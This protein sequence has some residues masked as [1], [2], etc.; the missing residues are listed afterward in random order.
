M[1]NQ[2]LTSVASSLYISWAWQQAAAA[3]G[4]SKLAHSKRALLE[5]GSLL[6]P[7]FGEASFALC[8]HGLHTQKATGN[9][10]PYL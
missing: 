2:A 3:Q 6:P 9:T 1:A 7:S 10:L 4:A 8:D 5:Y